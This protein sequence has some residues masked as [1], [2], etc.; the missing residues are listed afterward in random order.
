MSR[1]G[2]VSARDAADQWWLLSVY[3]DGWCQ[4]PAPARSPSDT[5]RQLRELLGWMALVVVL[6]GAAAATAR[7]APDA[8]W[9]SSVLGLASIGALVAAVVRMARRGARAPQVF[10]SSAEQAA[11]L[12]G[13]RRVALDAV[14]SVTVT[15]EAHEQVVTIALRKGRPLVYR[16]PDRTLARL[17]A[18]WSPAPP[19][20]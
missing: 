9:L 7:F 18:P 16:S 2:W 20:I 1:R 19:R 15:R 4:L 10:G 12:D 6:F 8:V 11:A 13:V 3:D 17:F 5:R 14:R